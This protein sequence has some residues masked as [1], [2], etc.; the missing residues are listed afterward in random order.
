MKR[1]SL[2]V[3]ILAVYFFSLRL[4]AQDT[5]LEHKKDHFSEP[6]LTLLFEI[7]LSV[8]EIDKCIPETLINRTFHPSITTN[9]DGQGTKPGLSLSYEIAKAHGG[10]LII[11]SIPG[12]AGLYCYCN[13]SLIT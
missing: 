6:Q 12:F 4:S 10:E 8:W 5:I 2:P 3:V 9:P 1:L 11:E 7:Q 13:H